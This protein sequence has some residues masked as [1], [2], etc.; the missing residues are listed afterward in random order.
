MAEM[1]GVPPGRDD[2]PG[3]RERKREQTRTALIDMAFALFAAKGYTATTVAEIADAAMVSRATFFNYFD[4][5][6]SLVLAW[7]RDLG[8]A[9]KEALEAALGAQTPP[10]GQ[11]RVVARALSSAGIERPVALRLL[12]GELYAPDKDRETEAWQAFDP[13]ATVSSIVAAGQQSGDFRTDRGAAELAAFVGT[14]LLALCA[15]ATE[16]SDQES[17]AEETTTLLLDA[18]ASRHEGSAATVAGGPPRKARR[19]PPRHP[20]AAP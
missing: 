15:R 7:A 5:K 1:S 10:D 17:L 16:T 20:P 8:E 2:P 4:R 3:L 6:E 18:L 11:L 13:I 19:A 9:I 14:T 12:I